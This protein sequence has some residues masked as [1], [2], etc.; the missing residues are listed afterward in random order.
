MELL[1]ALL[2]IL[3]ATRFAGEIAERA[4][5]AAL[6]GELVAGVI[7]GLLARQFSDYLPMLAELPEDEAFRAITDLGIF[8]LMLLGGIELH[9]KNLAKDSKAAIGVAAGGMVLPF[10]LGMSLAWAMLPDSSLK[11]AQ[12]LFLGVA[13]AITAIPVAVKALMDL[14]QLKSKAGQII[15]SAAIMDDILSLLLLAALTGMIRTKELPALDELGVM[16]LKTVAFFA[17]SYVLGRYVFPWISR[18]FKR[19]NASEFAFSG[20]LVFALAEAVLAEALGL[21]FILGAFFTGLFFSRRTPD[22]K[23]FEDVK[24]KVSGVTSGFLAPVFFAS[25]GFSLSLS[26]LV[27]TPLFLTLVLLSAILGKL[28]GAGA[29]A[30]WM[31][32]DKRDAAAVG[33]GMMGRGAVELVIADIALQG[34]LF[35]APEPVP[36]I[37]ASLF[38]TIVLMTIVTTLL[39][40]IGL[41][42][43]W[44]SK[45][46]EKDNEKDDD[47]EDK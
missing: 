4:G 1:F 46:G 23:T 32:L 42:L 26:P 24:K 13:L 27:E 41:R 16:G 21:H 33:I 15:I 7:L 36:P 18:F 6:V 30:L 17:L 12:V 45:A 37:V 22:R 35:E 3:V 28:I 47:R 14:G 19:A 20:L 43:L 34:G 31:G 9:P 39:A 11:P 25:I 8:F 40:P 29:P 10:A 44:S 38:P 2:I 5:Q